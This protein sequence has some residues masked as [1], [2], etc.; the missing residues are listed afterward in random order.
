MIRKLKLLLKG[1]VDW[2]QSVVLLFMSL[3]VLCIVIITVSFIFCGKL[4]RRRMK[5]TDVNFLINKIL[6]KKKLII[7]LPSE[8]RPMENGG[9]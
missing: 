4:G 3:V 6:G 5:D 8:N 7:M 1:G 9:Y 2:S